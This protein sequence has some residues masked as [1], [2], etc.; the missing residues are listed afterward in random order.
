MERTPWALQAGLSVTCEAFAN[1]NHINAVHSGRAS[2]SISP[3]F[4]NHAKPLSTIG[5]GNARLAV[6][7]VSEPSETFPVLVRGN[8]EVHSC[9]AIRLVPRHHTVNWAFLLEQVSD[10]C[11]SSL[12]GE[13][14]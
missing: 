14:A 3:D 10:F 4:E 13:A 12:N 6:S 11:S 5:T 8:E 2:R 9:R 1:F 7:A